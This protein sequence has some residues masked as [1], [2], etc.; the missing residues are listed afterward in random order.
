MESKPKDPQLVE[1]MAALKEVVIKYP[2]VDSL[3]YISNDKDAALTGMGC[4]ACNATNIMG[5]LLTGQIKHDAETA[6]NEVK[7]KAQKA[8]F[9]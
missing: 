9:N 8:H 4:A 6:M 2:E 3:I 1:M 5:L 7:E